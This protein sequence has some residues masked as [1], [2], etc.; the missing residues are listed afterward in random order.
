MN[1]VPVMVTIEPAAPEVGTTVSVALETT[2][3]PPLCVKP[4]L[5][6]STQALPEHVLEPFA[7]AGQSAFVQ[8][9]LAAMQPPPHA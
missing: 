2:Q 5:Q 4:V 7:T 1:P 9:A 8:H 3:A 6:L